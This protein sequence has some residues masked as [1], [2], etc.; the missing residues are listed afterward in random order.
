MIAVASIVALLVS[1]CSAENQ[2]STRR[3]TL[4]GG[5]EHVVNRQAPQDS[6][7]ARWTWSEDLALAFADTAEGALLRPAAALR[8]S[9]GH[10]VATDVAPWSIKLYDPSGR[11]VRE[12]GREGGGPGEYRYVQLGIHE[13]TILAFD[14]SQQRLTW[15]TL[16]GTVLRTAAASSIYYGPRLD[17]TDRG[18]VLL[19]GSRGW[20][21]LDANGAVVDSVV[22]PPDW[23]GG[24]RWWEFEVNDGPGGSPRLVREPI[25]FTPAR[26]SALLADGRLVHGTT[27]RYALVISNDGTD[28]TRLITADAPRVPVADS[29]RL[30]AW[31]AANQGHGVARFVQP[32]RR[33][34]SESD[35][36]SSRP[37]WSSIATDQRGRLWVALPSPERAMAAWDVFDSTG[38]LMGRVRP[39]VPAAMRG[40]WSSDR[41]L[42]IDEDAEGRPVVRVYRLTGL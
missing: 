11:F 38:A 7:R 42:V 20:A 4:P 16:D 37:L 17:V 25:P 22:S 18:Q 13:D 19:R 26:A 32:M 41:L 30:R 33:V 24:K 34:I 1:A 27:D 8:T 9:S 21:R 5:L 3:E 31:E 23:E 10:I 6:G 29:A 28:S 39:P 2:P 14:P 12:V 15:F 35:I 36:P 40:T